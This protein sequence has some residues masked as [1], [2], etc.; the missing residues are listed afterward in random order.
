M[1][2]AIDTMPDSP[3]SVAVVASLIALIAYTYGVITGRRSE[4]D[5]LKRRYPLA[6]YGSGRFPLPSI[7]NRMQWFKNGPRLIHDAYQKV[8]LRL[9]WIELSMRACVIYHS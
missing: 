8:G 5:G 2:L 4:F 6:S 3:Y 7:W 9:N 1:A